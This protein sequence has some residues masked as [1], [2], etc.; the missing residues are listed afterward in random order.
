MKGKNMVLTWIITALFLLFTGW[1]GIA[2]YWGL[3]QEKDVPLIISGGLTAILVL[4]LIPIMIMMVVTA[5]KRRKEIKE[6]DEDDLSQ[7]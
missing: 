4:I 6:E 3:S 5:I 2:I 7:Y 1:I